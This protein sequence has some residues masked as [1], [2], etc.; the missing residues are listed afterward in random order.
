MAKYNYPD[1]YDITERPLQTQELF[2]NENYIKGGKNKVE[3]NEHTDKTKL[4]STFWMK[5]WVH[6]NWI[7]SFNKW[8]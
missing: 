5:L 7:F 6:P 1:K 2:C 3:W 8:F 4:T